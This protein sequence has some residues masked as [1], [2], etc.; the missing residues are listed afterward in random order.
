[1]RQH[2]LLCSLNSYWGKIFLLGNKD[3][4][5]KLFPNIIQ[6]DVKRYEIKPTGNDTKYISF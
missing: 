3:F 4:M 1:M 6:S 5:I 2:G